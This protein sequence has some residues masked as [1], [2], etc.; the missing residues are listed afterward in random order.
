MELQAHGECRDA[1]YDR[2]D[3][4]VSKSAASDYLYA[5]GAACE[6]FRMKTP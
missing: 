3:L 5:G 4:P 2:G 6:E 1:W